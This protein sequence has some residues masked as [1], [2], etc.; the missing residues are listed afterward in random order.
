[1]FGHLITHVSFSECCS[2]NAAA[3]LPLH[4]QLL[5]VEDPVAQCFDATT[6]G[7]DTSHATSAGPGATAGV[8]SGGATINAILI[9]AETLSAM[10]GHS[11]V[12]M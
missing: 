4:D 8:G 1:M 6:D 5:V 7:P 10:K 12:Q 3:M 2:L 9:A 11:M